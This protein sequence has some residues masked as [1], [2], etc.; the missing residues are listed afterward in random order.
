MR[1]EKSSASGAG[2]FYHTCV[3]VPRLQP[4]TETVFHHLAVTVKSPPARLAEQAELCLSLVT[5]RRK[6]FLL[7]ASRIPDR[8]QR[9]NE[10]PTSFGANGR[11]GL[12][13]FPPSNVLVWSP[14]T[15]SRQRGE[16]PLGFYKLGNIGNLPG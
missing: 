6:N 16:G 12:L 8:Y 15:S 13:I 9:N 10:M 14:A 1:K 5:F 4:D 3:C 7:F 11:P 2:L